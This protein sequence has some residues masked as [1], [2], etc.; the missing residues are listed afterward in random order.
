MKK[1]LLISLIVFFTFSICL[2]AQGPRLNLT[3]TWKLDVSKSQLPEMG[4]RFAQDQETTLIIKQERRTIIIE[5]IRGEMKTAMELTIGGEE[6][7]VESPMMGFARRSGTDVK[8]KTIAKAE[9]SE[10]RSSIIVTL[11]TTMSMQD[12]TFEIKTVSSYSLSDD[13]NTLTEKQTRSTSRGDSESVLV[14]NKSD[15]QEKSQNRPQVGPN[16]SGTW[17]L[18]LEKSQMPQMGGGRAPQARETT[19]IIGQEDNVI[20]IETVTI[21]ERGER[22]S[23]MSLVI[24]GGETKVE[25]PMGMMGRGG[26]QAGGPAPVA[27]AKAELKDRT[28]IIT[29]NTTMSFQDRT[30]EIKTV[31]SYSLSE[32]G[33]TLTEKQIRTF[34]DRESE[35]NLVYNKVK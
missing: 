34:G 12:R 4:G 35:S 32:G 18:N 28:L 14:Y 17:K 5:T 33:K 11:N 29:S 7:E 8:S 10:D 30:F 24:G 2:Y 19:L 25:S 26:A 13:G 22:K 3:G 27:L 1:T 9:R 31:S 16:F 21:S 15:S 6:Q 23:A 20:K